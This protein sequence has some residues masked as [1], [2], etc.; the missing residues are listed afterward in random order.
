MTLAVASRGGNDAERT[1]TLRHHIRLMQVL[2]EG[3]PLANA[4]M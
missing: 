1:E 4:P 3:V 2:G